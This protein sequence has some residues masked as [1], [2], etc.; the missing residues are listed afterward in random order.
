ML[1][2]LAASYI[3]YSVPSSSG[4]SNSGLPG[5]FWAT[6]PV[7]LALVVVEIVAM[8]KMFA[9]AGRPGWA[10]II[11]I[12]NNWV[13]FEIAGKPGWWALTF[14]LGVIPFVGWLV[15]FVLF[16]LAMLELAKRFNKST[17]FAVFGLILFSFVGLAILGFGKDEYHP[18]TEPSE[19]EKPQTPAP[20]EPPAA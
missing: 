4:A 7:F 16:V 5:F 2:L 6:L 9:K 14:F 3:N 19:G 8:W 18:P 1:G 15:Y 13:M 11:P 20:A 17:V 12:Y 10:A